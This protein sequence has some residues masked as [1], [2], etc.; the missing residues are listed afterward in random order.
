[1]RVVKVPSLG[2]DNDNVNVH[3]FQGFLSS[4]GLGPE[5]RVQT[6]LCQT[7]G[8]LCESGLTV[9]SST[10][11]EIIGNGSLEIGESQSVLSPLLS[12]SF[13]LSLL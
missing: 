7:A 2:N 6:E 9:L 11:L 12:H 5:S 13:P 3:G 10:V 1:M 4:V 8:S